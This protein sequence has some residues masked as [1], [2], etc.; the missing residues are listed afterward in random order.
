MQ[1]LLQPHHQEMLELC[2][3][4]G[5]QEEK[6]QEVLPKSLKDFLQRRQHFLNFS[7]NGLQERLYDLQPVL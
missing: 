4:A 2:P 7:T 3:P 1:G 5:K 6:E